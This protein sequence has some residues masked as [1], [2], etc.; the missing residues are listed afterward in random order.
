MTPEE[1]AADLQAKLDIQIEENKKLKDGIQPLESL[2]AK[3]VKLEADNLKTAEE[4]KKIKLDLC[5]ADAIKEF[6]L[7]AGFNDELIGNTPE[8]IKAKAK[9]FHDTIA[10]ATAAGVKMKEDE[11]KNAWG[12]LPRGSL[13]GILSQSDM[14]A[15]YEDA[16]KKGDIAAMLKNKFTRLVGK[17]TNV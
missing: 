9:K 2:Q 14:D 10:T 12:S 8:E 4:N 11:L 1:I 6:P 7:S 13:P 17:M 16:K 15:Q 5:K 3:I